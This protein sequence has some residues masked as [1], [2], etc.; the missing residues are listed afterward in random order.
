VVIEVHGEH[1]LRGRVDQA[2]E[3]LLARLNL[4][5]GV[6]A[7]GE[8]RFGVLAVKQVVDRAER[9]VSKPCRD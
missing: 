8:V 4:P 2:E 1:V 7:G 9:A 5:E 3:V 6:L